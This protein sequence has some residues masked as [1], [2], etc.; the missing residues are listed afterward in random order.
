MKKMIIALLCCVVI[1]AAG[2]SILLYTA[3]SPSCS[4]VEVTAQPSPDGRF[5]YSVFRK[6]CGATT[7]YVTGVALRPADQPLADDPG[8]FVLIIEGDVR[9]QAQWKTGNGLE[10]TAPA[11]A[12]TF[13]KL[14]KWKNIDVA[15]VSH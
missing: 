7:D 3:L 13:K 1:A 9:L 10:I 6:D 5:A 12:K 11:E 4:L 2:Y 15:V 8:A 14:D